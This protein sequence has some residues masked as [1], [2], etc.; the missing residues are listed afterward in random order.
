MAMVK[1]KM[2]LAEAC[3][4][5]ARIQG[6]ARQGIDFKTQDKLVL[7]R[8]KEERSQEE[9]KNRTFFELFETWLADGVSRKD[10][11]AELRRTFNKDVL[12]YIGNRRVCDLVES[13]IRRVLQKV[14]KDR[15]G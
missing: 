6:L 13:D 1:G 11:N 8:M 10:D 14:V 5:N 9:T 15:G 4:D 3:I 7:Q 2:S 12:P